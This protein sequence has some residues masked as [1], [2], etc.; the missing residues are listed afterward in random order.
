MLKNDT[1][2]LNV[3]NKNTMDNPI[4]QRTVNR[5][6]N[7]VPPEEFPCDIWEVIETGYFVSVVY[8]YHCCTDPDYVLMEFFSDCLNKG[9]VRST[10]R[11][12]ADVF[13]DRNS[14]GSNIPGF[15]IEAEDPDRGFIFTS[16]DGF[17]KME[18]IIVRAFIVAEIVKENGLISEN[19]VNDS[20]IDDALFSAE[21][22]IEDN[23]NGMIP[24]KK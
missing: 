20:V 6:I 14:C 24:F 21:T 22:F 8:P 19:D 13:H 12:C 5:L 10:L 23:L 9:T 3:S 16:E 11:I 18:G 4:I 1:C 15:Y 2:I 7:G 17:Q